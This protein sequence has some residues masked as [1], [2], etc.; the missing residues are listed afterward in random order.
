MSC[1]RYIASLSLMYILNVKYRSIYCY[2]LLSYFLPK[3]LMMVYLDFQLT[4]YLGKPKLN[5]LTKAN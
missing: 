4:N 2:I 5:K 3:K 1:H